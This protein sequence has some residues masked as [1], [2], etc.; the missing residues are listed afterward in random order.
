MADDGQ[1]FVYGVGGPESPY[2]EPE[3]I[4]LTEQ[5]ATVWRRKTK[6]KVR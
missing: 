6:S 4:L 3:I 2:V 1:H 5:E